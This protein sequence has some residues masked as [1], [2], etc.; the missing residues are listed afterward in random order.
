[1]AG[2]MRISVLLALSL[3]FA[4]ANHGLIP[5]E[6]PEAWVQK[7]MT[8]LGV[9]TSSPLQSCI[10]TVL[11][12]LHDSGAACHDLDE[13]LKTRE[14]VDDLC[15]QEA[16]VY[17]R[18]MVEQSVTNLID[19][20]NSS[21]MQ[22]EVIQKEHD[23]MQVLTSELTTSI[24]TSQQHILN[25]QEYLRQQLDE[26]TQQLDGKLSQSLQHNEK[27][28]ED[29]Q[30]ALSNQ[31]KLMDVSHSVASAVTEII[32]ERYLNQY[33]YM[34]ADGTIDFDQQVH[35]QLQQ[36]YLNACWT[37]R[38]L[39]MMI[40]LGILFFTAIYYRDPAHESQRL[41]GLVKSQ[42]DAI[43][44]SVQAALANVVA[45]STFGPAAVSPPTA[46][47]EDDEG[48]AADP[49][50]QFYS[51]DEGEFDDD[52]S[53]D[54]GDA[55]EDGSDESDWGSEEVSGKQIRHFLSVCPSL[56]FLCC[57]VAHLLTCT[58]DDDDELPLAATE[59]GRSVL[60]WS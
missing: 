53:D 7:A 24:Q 56:S 5:T 43:L 49:T 46:S 17:Q 20:A 33:V 36:D 37:M 8:A 25:N 32:A 4:V 13:E 38:K 26:S 28:L 52:D 21:A 14:R 47:I 23:R 59:T 57:V 6:D 58:P 48:E 12:R 15:Q 60:S 35:P 9:V 44:Q 19:A 45:P 41:L 22:L 51:D 10:H 2:W 55:D 29:Q 1:M 27:L 30:V 40:D 34:N 42:N 11:L 31:Q 3:T 50:F 18:L 54:E 16:N 39:V